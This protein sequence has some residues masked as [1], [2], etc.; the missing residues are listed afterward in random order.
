ML[1]GAAQGSR[2]IV[3]TLFNGQTSTKLFAFDVTSEEPHNGGYDGVRLG[4]AQNPGPPD[5]E[6]DS[7]QE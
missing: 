1:R 7:A 6:R 3:I 5:Y 4:E 2:S